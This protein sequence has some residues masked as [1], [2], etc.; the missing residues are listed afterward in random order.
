MMFYPDVAH[1]ETRNEDPNC[2]RNP[3]EKVDYLLATTPLSNKDIKFGRGS[4]STNNPANVVYRRAIRLL[5]QYHSNLSRSEKVQLIRIFIQALRARGFRF[6]KD[7][8]EA[9]EDL[10]YE[11]ISASFR[12]SRRGRDHN[13]FLA[14]DVEAEAAEVQ[15]TLRSVSSSSRESPSMHQAASANV[16][17]STKDVIENRSA[18]VET[19][20]APVKFEGKTFYPMDLRSLDHGR[21]DG[22]STEESLECLDIFVPV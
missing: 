7:G 11:K 18:T 20:R 16:V 6:L 5:G 10:I 8:E 3:Q 22:F 4:G 9:N 15:M 14:G 17:I 19:L 12:S 13:T 2:P 1:Q 21:D